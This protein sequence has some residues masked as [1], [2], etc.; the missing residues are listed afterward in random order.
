[1]EA[2]T[3]GLLGT[4]V[5]AAGDDDAR[6]PDD[7]AVDAPPSRYGQ[8]NNNQLATG[9]VKVGG[10]RQ[11]SVENHTSMT[12][13]DDRSV[14]WMTE[15]GMDGDG[16][17]DNSGD[18]DDDRNGDDR[19]SDGG[20]DNNG[21]GGGNSN[22]NSFGHR[23]QSTNSVNGNSDGDGGRRRQHHNGGSGGVA[24]EGAGGG[25]PAVIVAAAA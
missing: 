10:G 8:K 22:R 5:L 13:G 3:H 4:C 6:G 2:S 21:G 15:W 7:R 24:R 1:L 11:E 20:D 14:Q 12:T 23:H 19:N 18:G 17:N 9:A 25:C 16:N